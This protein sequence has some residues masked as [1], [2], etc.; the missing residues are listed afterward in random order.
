[1]SFG[2]GFAACL[3]TMHLTG[4]WVDLYNGTHCCLSNCSSLY[5]LFSK[6]E[7]TQANA[8]RLIIPVTLDEEAQRFGL[9]QNFFT[10]SSL[11]K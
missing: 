10:A 5:L 3:I 9:I 1:M 2:S 4:D 7:A 6:L 8:W 11:F